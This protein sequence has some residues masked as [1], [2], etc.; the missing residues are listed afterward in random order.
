[1][2]QLICSPRVREKLERELAVFDIPV[3]DDGTWVLVERGFELPADKPALVF[4]PLDYM[5]AVRMLVAGVRDDSGGQRT[6]TGQSGSTFTVLSP[7]EVRYLEAE[8]DGVVA[9]TASGRYRVRRTLQYYELS[10]ST[11]GF[12]RVNKSQLANIV[13][14][15]EIVPWFNSRFV[16]RM[17]GGEELEVSKTYSGRLRTALRLGEVK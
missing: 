7:R 8:G 16:L 10:W 12:I 1:M 6:L 15:R 17:T 11:I 2:V 9:A 14:V 5:E 4:D 13:H 3:E